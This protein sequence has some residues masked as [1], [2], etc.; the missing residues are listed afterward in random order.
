M[1][2]KLKPSSWSECCREISQEWMTIGNTHSNYAISNNFFGNFE[3]FI[4]MTN[5]IFVCNKQFQQHANL[6]QCAATLSY[7]IGYFYYLQSKAMEQIAL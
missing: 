7:I 1:K 6:D 3:K 4:S 5:P 2:K